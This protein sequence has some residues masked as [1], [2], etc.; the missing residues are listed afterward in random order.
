MN[1][2]R[3]C[4]RR[5]P[6]NGPRRQSGIVLV[7][8]DGESEK[9]YFERLSDL[10]RN[11][12]IKSVATAKTGPSVLIRKTK[13]HIRKSD[14]DPK[15][16]DIVAIVMD[17]D[18]RFAEDEIR[19]MEQECNELGFRLFLSNPSFEVWLMC[20]RRI[21]THPCT[22]AELFD[23]MNDGMGRYNKSKGIEF[24]DRSVCMAV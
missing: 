11:V 22:A 24:D 16:G 3:R 8:G 5:Y 14:L 23:E 6:V 4:R 2:G 18:D 15:R 7:M 17:L 19:R 1:D 9:V 12:H 13:E 21:P 10:C 20:H